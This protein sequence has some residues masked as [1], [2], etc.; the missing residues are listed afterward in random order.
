MPYCTVHSDPDVVDDLVWVER[1][2][3]P[4]LLNNNLLIR[5]DRARRGISCVVRNGRRG[6]TI[7]CDTLTNHLMYPLV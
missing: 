5:R 7:G 1:M 4:L 2:S 3:G 6:F